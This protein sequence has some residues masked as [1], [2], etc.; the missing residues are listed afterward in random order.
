MGLLGVLFLPPAAMLTITLKLSFRRCNV[1]YF[2]ADTVITGFIF[3][4][5]SIHL[6]DSNSPRDHLPPSYEITGLW[7][8]YMLLRF[9]IILV[10]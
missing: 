4:Y 8:T 3:M 10:F 5:G 2:I 9:L 1:K 7:I 6:W